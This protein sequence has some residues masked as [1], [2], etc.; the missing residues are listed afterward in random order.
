[1]PHLIS[2]LIRTY[3]SQSAYEQDAVHLAQLGYVV[4]NVSEVPASSRWGALIRR[5]FG[6]MR[7]R[8]TVT[9][10]DAGMGSS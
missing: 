2:S 1:M 8:L 10:S 6:S 5:L 3:T 9:Y 7:R 4:A